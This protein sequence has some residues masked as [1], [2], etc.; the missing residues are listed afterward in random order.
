LPTS[1][2]TLKARA[3]GNALEIARSGTPKSPFYI[4][5]QVNGKLFSVH[6]EGV[7]LFMPGGSGER[8]EIDLATAK[9]IVGPYAV[10][11]QSAPEVPEPVTAHGLV[12]VDLAH[13]G[14][15]P[16]G[17]SPLDN[18]LVQ[19]DQSM[20]AREESSIRREPEVAHS[21]IP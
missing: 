3:S 7:R 20:N 15:W 14:E 10:T 2:A 9:Q 11:E 18:D 19:P 21:P 12:N 6:S 5:G 16:P 8:T 1:L 4:T 13:E 17:V